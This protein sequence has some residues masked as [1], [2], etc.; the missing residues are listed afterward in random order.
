MPIKRARLVLIAAIAAAFACI[1][2]Q[3]P[4]SADAARG[5]IDILR[6]GCGSC[7]TVEGIRIAR[8]L[9]G[10]P[11]TGLRSRM[12]IAGMLRNSPPNLVRWIHNPKDVN[13]NT[14][15]PALGVSEQDAADIA[16]YIYSIP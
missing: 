5:R 8:G 13:P 14:A 11:L 12:Y 4:L 2:C 1:A 15:M 10:P 6:Y 9:V 3:R 7:H 16:A